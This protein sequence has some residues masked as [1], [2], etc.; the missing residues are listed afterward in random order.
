M[1]PSS[2]A[3]SRA[4]TPL[5]VAA[6]SLAAGLAILALMV[7]RADILVR[8][9]LVGHL[10]YVLLLLV[11]L[12]AAV[13]LFAL[14]RSYASYTGKVLNGT[15]ELGGPAVLVL[16]VVLLGFRLVPKPEVRFDQTIF[17]SSESGQ[18][19]LRNRG[20]LRLDFGADRRYEEI[21]TKGE[22]RFIGIPAD[23]RGRQVS[24]A[25]E[26]ADDYELVEDSARVT[27]GDEA[28]Y[29]RVK[30]RMVPFQGQVLDSKG[31]PLAGAK[32]SLPRRSEVMTDSNGRFYL[33]LPADLPESDRT[34]TITAAGHSP[35]RGQVVLG[36]SNPLSV[37]LE[38]ER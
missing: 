26:G 29:L 11:G 37:R 21:G 38:S 16:L 13:C 10:W 1:K 25:L 30:P 28:T 35:W 32:L 12:A 7:W 27:L 33:P 14:F 34:A 15:L 23:Q 2:T 5:F 8:L 24:V 9:G 20:K 22:A 3:S 17:V 31:Q 6:I 36:G 18:L 4:R 19:V